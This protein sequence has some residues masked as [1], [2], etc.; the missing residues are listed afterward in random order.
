VG[1][2]RGPLGL[3][4]TAEELLG[5]KKSEYGLETENTAVGIRCAD[6]VAAYIRKRWQQLRL[7]AVVARSVYFTRLSSVYQKIIF[8][9]QFHVPPNMLS[10]VF[11]AFSRTP[12]YRLEGH[13]SIQ[14]PHR[15]ELCEVK[16]KQMRHEINTKNFD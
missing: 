3:V 1:L 7:Q 9:F 10:H 4:S 8:V 2:E 16:Y 12:G 5:I 11:E 15:W 6:D 13:W 14:S